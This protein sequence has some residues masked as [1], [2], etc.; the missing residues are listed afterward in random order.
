METARIDEFLAACSDEELRVLAARMAVRV[1]KAQTGAPRMT[2]ELGRTGR[3]EERFDVNYLGTLTRLTDVRPGER[4][5]YSATI[6]DISRSGMCLWVD[7]NFVPSR[8]VEVTFSA[9]GGKIKSCQLE[10]VRMRKKNTDG[11]AWLELGCQIINTEEVRRLRL[12][13]EQLAKVRSKLQGCGRINILVV[14]LKSESLARIFGAPAAVRR[15]APRFVA[16]AREAQEALKKDGAQVLILGRGEELLSNRQVQSLF[17][18]KPSATATLAIIEHE[19]TRT[20]LLQAGI[21][22][23]L[24]EGSCQEFMLRAIERAL[25]G[26]A[27][28]CVHKQLCGEVLLVSV[29]STRVNLISYYLEENGYNVC[30][31]SSLAEA[32]MRRGQL[33]AV[34]ADYQPGDPEGFRELLEQFAGLPLVAICDRIPDGQEAVRSGASNYLCMPLEKD[35]IRMVIRQL[36]ARTVSAGP[37]Q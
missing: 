18:A 15:Y 8:V 30:T 26:G 2:D 17:E 1:K 6:R 31:A 5:E 25:E 19:E 20:P 3:R 11:G 27:V 37:K 28:R 14:G 32:R 23:C 21:D 16:S 10:I 24:S 33:D 36:M 29:H 34:F 4:K 12:Q 9:P 35:D 22:E 13:E 7:T